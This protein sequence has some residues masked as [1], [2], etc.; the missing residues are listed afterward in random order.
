MTVETT[1]RNIVTTIR[2]A[3][4]N[5]GAGTETILDLSS[6]ERLDASGLQALEDLAAAAGQQSV[7]PTLRG[8]NIAVYKVLKLTKLT[9]RF[10]FV[11]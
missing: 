11:D 9:Q 8:A 1:D 3:A 2:D 10:S 7:K 4:K 6:V 5:L